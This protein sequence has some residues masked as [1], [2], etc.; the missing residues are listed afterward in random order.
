MRI[1]D[2]IEAK[3]AKLNSQH[4]G[5]KRATESNSG[6]KIARII[7]HLNENMGKLAVSI[8]GVDFDNNTIEKMVV[9]NAFKPKPSAAKY[10]SHATANGFTFVI[11]VSQ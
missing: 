10:E 5:V 11:E 3:L 1:S 4:R 8:N 7:E 6:T 9:P 2:F